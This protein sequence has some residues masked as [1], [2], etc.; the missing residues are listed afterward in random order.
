MKSV[1]PAVLAL[2]PAL[3]PAA[4][5]PQGA[6]PADLGFL[7]RQAAA[8]SPL[9]RAAGARLESARHAPSQA[10]APPDPEIILSYLN[11]GVSRLTLGESEFSTLSITWTQELRYPGKLAGAGEVAALDAERAA[12]DF[13]RQRL[14]VGAAVKT[15]YADLYRLDRT[16]AILD[17]TRSILATL[18]DSARKR[19]EIGEGI[20]ES[21][22]KAQTRILR[23]EAEIARVEQDRRTAEVRLN[24]AIGRTADTPIGPA[25]TL[26]EATLTGDPEELADAAAGASPEIA[27]MDAMARRAEA[28]LRLARLD[29]HPDFIWSASYQNRDGLDPMVMGSLGVRLPLH[30]DRKQ[31]QAVAQKESE[32]LAARQDLAEVR[33]RTRAAVG[34]LV[35]RVQRAD[36][37]LLLL[38]EGVV[39]QAE[40]TL[41]S[42]RASY[43]AG[44]IDLLD[45]LDDLSALLNDRIEIAAQE[46]ERLQAFSAL[47]PLLARELIRVP[48]ADAEAGDS[49]ALGRGPTGRAIVRSAGCG[50]SSPRGERPRRRPHRRR[51]LPRRR[52]EGR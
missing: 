8:T 7:L 52:R 30:R 40:S 5:A 48:A 42:A 34:E 36:R 27:A 1:A 6:L 21:V 15:A 51:L 13:E 18:S 33:V 9:L 38:R 45:V 17:E 32:V 3:T 4:E 29:L 22:L 10:Q 11:D 20:Q 19:Y 2:L 28:G 35:S 39:P 12:A 50:W 44:R 24:A 14:L 47:E 37:L 16:R 23:L 43:V 31:A 46:A 49:R 26:P 41:E 25:T